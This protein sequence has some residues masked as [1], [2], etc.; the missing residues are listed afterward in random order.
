MEKTGYDWSSIQLSD[1]SIIQV[2]AETPSGRIMRAK[3]KQDD[4]L[5]VLKERRRSEVLFLFLFVIFK[6]A[7][8]FND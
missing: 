5:V 8:V 2:V 1:F 3:R 7:V 6:F 4:C